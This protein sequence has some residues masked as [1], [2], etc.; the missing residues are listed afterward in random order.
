MLVKVKQYITYYCASK[1]KLVHKKQFG[2]MRSACASVCVEAPLLL[3]KHHNCLNLVTDQEHV[4]S[5]NW[6]RNWK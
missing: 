4:F 6:N 1:L 2:H 5:R 3:W